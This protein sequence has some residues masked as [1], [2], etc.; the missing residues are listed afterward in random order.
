MTKRQDSS[1]KVSPSG[2]KSAGFTLLQW[3]VLAGLECY[4]R[5]HGFKF[6]TWYISSF[7]VVTF[8]VINVFGTQ[9]NAFYMYVSIATSSFL[10]EI[11]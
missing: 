6:S 2:R 4:S 7:S 5:S 9:G 3:K 1:G 10:K 8:S 11:K